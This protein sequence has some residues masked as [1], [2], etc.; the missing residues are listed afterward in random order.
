[1]TTITFNQKLKIRKKHFENPIV[2]AGVPGAASI[3]TI[4]SCIPETEKT[5]LATWFETFFCQ[6]K[7]LKTSWTRW[8][9]YF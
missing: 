1:M 2:G 5:L 9:R 6:Q 8:F 3:K 7:A 4:N